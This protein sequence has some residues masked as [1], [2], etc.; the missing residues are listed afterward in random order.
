MD[1]TITWYPGKQNTVILNRKSCL[2]LADALRNSCLTTKNSNLATDPSQSANCHNVLQESVFGELNETAN[3]SLAANDMINEKLN[4]VRSTCNNIVQ[5]Q[6]SD[7]RCRSLAIDIKGMKLDLV[8]IQNKQKQLETYIESQIFLADKSCEGDQIFQLK[9][10]LLN[11]VEHR[12]KFENDIVILVTGRNTEIE[13]R[14]L[15]SHYKT[16]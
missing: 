12:E 14:I 9:Q 5:G 10:N 16:S 13:E 4:E 15:L 6:E 3:Q 7:C 1:L 8:I 11:E 2:K